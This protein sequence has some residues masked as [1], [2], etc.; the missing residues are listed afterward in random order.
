MSS[1]TIYC[2]YLTIYKGNKLPPFYIGSSTVK[3]VESGYHGSVVSKKYKSIWNS[4][5]KKHPN[6]FKTKILSLH[7]T[8][9]EAREKELKFQRE[10]NV[11][12]STLY[13]NMGYATVNGCFGISRKGKDNPMYGN[14]KFGENNH[15][16]IK[17]WAISPDGV[18]YIATGIRQFAKAHNLIAT[19]M[20]EVLKGRQTHHKN[21]TFGYIE[22]SDLLTVEKQ[23]PGKEIKPKPDP[24][25]YKFFNT[26]TQEIF[27][28]RRIDLIHK[29]NLSSSSVCGLINKRLKTHY[30]WI[31][32]EKLS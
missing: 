15:L 2:T 30:N 9:E 32:V 8:G 23:E 27:E 17:F 16:S 14:G 7:E 25:I 19:N 3:N 11:V 1:T 31:L 29:Y 18:K 10:L 6:L 13:I 5:L 20:V 21:W 12:E 24:S 22:E 28:G 4:E 26:E